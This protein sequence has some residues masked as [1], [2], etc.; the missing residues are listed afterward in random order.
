MK[1][2]KLFI[3]LAVML[4]A[5][6]I[7]NVAMGQVR[8]IVV[9]TDNTS[10]YLPTQINNGSFNSEPWMDFNI[11]EARITDR[12]EGE[13]YNDQ[14]IDWAYPNGVNEGWNTSESVVQ[15][16][17]L[18]E[19]LEQETIN[20]WSQGGVWG[21]GYGIEMNAKSSAVLYQDLSTKGY[22]IIRWSLKHAVRCDYGPITQSMKVEI[23][24]PEYSGSDIVPAYGATPA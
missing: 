9:Q 16:G 1:K 14:S 17:T 23:G 18:F 21:C 11:F 3:F 24:A 15:S 12:M 8:S 22:D 2:I 7:T 4:F 5:A 10:T 20:E 13:I 6:S 19:W